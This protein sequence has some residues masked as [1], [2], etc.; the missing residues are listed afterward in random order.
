MAVLHARVVVGSGGGPDKTILASPRYAAGSRF[1][2]GAAY[3][4][5]PGDSG[6]ALLRARATAAG[7]P[8]LAVPDRGPLDL[9][10]F[11]VLLAACRRQR[12][13]IWHGHD[14]KSLLLGLLIRPL[15]SMLVV[16]TVHGWVQLTPRTRMYYAL[17]RRLLRLLDH[18][19][20][21]DEELLEQVAACGVPGARRSLLRNGVE[22]DIFRRSCPP[23][24][25]THRRQLGGPTDL[26]VIG[27][28]GRLSDEKGFDLLLQAAARL[29]DEGTRFELWIAG[30]GP[31]ASSLRCQL[32]RLGLESQ[33]RLVG[34]QSDAR[35]FL[36]A[37]DVFVLS[38]RREGLP[39]ALLE[40]LAMELPAV[41]TAV[42]GVPELIRDGRTGLLV[43]AEDPVRLAE[44]M[45][46][47]LRSAELRAR[48]A[49]AGRSIVE[50]DFSFAAR[51][52]R[53]LAVYDRLLEAARP[54]SP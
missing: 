7:C 33:V 53:E 35:A 1:R 6:F 5:A 20:A 17:E 24:A 48:L 32:S 26:P 18:V 38:S 11:R 19:F 40:A 47:L 44:A 25:A 15:H 14:Y 8:L 22:A 51:T 16:A 27:A 37:L 21:V 41:A 45:G 23:A 13:A 34:F 9:R 10:P 28:L 49:R 31:A 12:V 2:L 39:N 29:R 30:D 52:R 46:R 42:G 3:L 50:R 36:E 43:P 4:H 54:A